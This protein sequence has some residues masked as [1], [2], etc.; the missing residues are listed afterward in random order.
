L[1]PHG[2]E[3]ALNPQPLPPHG[4]EVALN[5]QP[6]PPHGEAVSLNPQPLPPHEGGLP[7]LVGAVLHNGS[8]AVSGLLNSATHL[9]TATLGP[10]GPMP[11]ASGPVALNPQLLSPHG[12]PTI[13]THSQNTDAD[14]SAT[15]RTQPHSSAAEHDSHLA[16]RVASSL[17][18][19][20][21]AHGPDNHYPAGLSHS[22]AGAHSP[23]GIHEQMHGADHG[24]GLGDH[25]DHGGM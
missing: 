8:Q 14:T 6:L 15:T 22:D 3:V 17:S 12:D 18:A 2:E 23:M 1:P 19:N 24:I 7:D 20:G 4:E 11:E 5:P 10:A 25:H 16:E 21:T 9:P 13:R